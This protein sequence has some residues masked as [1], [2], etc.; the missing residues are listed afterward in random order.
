MHRLE[1]VLFGCLG[2]H[3]AHRWTANC[4]GDRC[5]I[6]EVVFVRLDVG[7]YE[8][9]RHQSDLMAKFLEFASKVLRAR[10]S[11]HANEAGRMIGNELGEL[12]ACELLSKHRF[13]GAICADH[14]KAV[15]ADIDA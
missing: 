9:R 8:L 12:L 2:R 4:L 5:G 14:V 11:L 3:K 7:F 13:A 15:L 6:I 1:I 10:A